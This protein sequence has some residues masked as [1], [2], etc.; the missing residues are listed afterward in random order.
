MARTRKGYTPKWAIQ[1]S[2]RPVMDISALM[3]L[4]Q[5]KMKPI[6]H[7]KGEQ[8]KSR[9]SITFD[10]MDAGEETLF[11][12]FMRELDSYRSDPF[13]EQPKQSSRAETFDI[14]VQADDPPA[15]H[16]G[17]PTWATPAREEQTA[18]E[19]TAGDATQAF[20]A[21]AAK[22]T[23]KE[24][25]ELVASFSV[26]KVGKLTPDQRSRFIATCETAK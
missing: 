18:T 14:E 24:A 9:Y 16:P 11:L 3:K 25:K 12:N 1:E 21:Y 26:E 2:S 5:M 23:E 6:F 13:A 7:T 17:G 8:M 15:S 10:V 19:P 22:H 20:L 4:L